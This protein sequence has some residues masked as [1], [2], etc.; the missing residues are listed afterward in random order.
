MRKDKQHSVDLICLVVIFFLFIFCAISALLLGVRFYQNVVS[1]SREHQSGRAAVAYLREVVRQN[2]AENVIYL[3]TFDGV[4]SLCLAQEGEYVRYIYYY[5]GSLR[6]L[7]TK[8]GAS[9]GASDGDSIM[10]LT[11]FSMELGDGG[12]LLTVSLEDSEGST[13]ELLIHISSGEV[14]Y[15]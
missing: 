6:E 3:S 1:E 10:E 13:Y 15:E 2:D 9:V 12:D 14:A 4:D 8:V 5:D 7:Y 11:A